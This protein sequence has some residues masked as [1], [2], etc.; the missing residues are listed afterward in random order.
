MCTVAARGADVHRQPEA[1]LLLG[2]A[3]RGEER[4]RYDS[5]SDLSGRSAMRAG[6]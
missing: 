6:T 5:L 4:P 1:T 2:G 3:P